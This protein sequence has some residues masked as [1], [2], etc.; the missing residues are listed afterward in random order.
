MKHLSLYSK[1]Y[2]GKQFF[3]SLTV[4]IVTRGNRVHERLFL[5][6]IETLYVMLEMLPLILFTQIGG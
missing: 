4:K 5:H 2:L 6:S 1:T 3:G